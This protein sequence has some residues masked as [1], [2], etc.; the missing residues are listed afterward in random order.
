MQG[1]GSR[2]AIKVY[3]SKLYLSKWEAKTSD[4]SS[5]SH[6]FFQVLL[7]TRGRIFWSLWSFFGFSCRRGKKRKAK[8]GV[9]FRGGT[10]EDAQTPPQHYDWV[11]DIIWSLNWTGWRAEVW[12]HPEA[13]KTM[14]KYHKK[15]PLWET[16]GVTANIWSREAEKESIFVKCFIETYT[17]CLKCN[18]VQ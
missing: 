12:T 5:S 17:V 9:D 7:R 4:M 1:E 14:F 6:C 8:S 11:Q 15:E 18:A 16:K 13:V 3:I 2:R 10:S